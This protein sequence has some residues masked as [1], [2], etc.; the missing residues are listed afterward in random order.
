MRAQAPAPITLS[1]G[2]VGPAFSKVAT[3]RELEDG[4][5]LVIDSDERILTV[6]DWSSLEP[7]TIGRAGDGLASIDSLPTW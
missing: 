7:R 4:R 6:V 2:T 3:V 1:S 5:T